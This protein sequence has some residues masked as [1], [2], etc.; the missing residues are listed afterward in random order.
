MSEAD[1]PT[2]AFEVGTDS[3][4]GVAVHGVRHPHDEAALLLHGTDERRQLLTQL[5]GT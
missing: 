3:L 1:R 2:A 4:D 5:L